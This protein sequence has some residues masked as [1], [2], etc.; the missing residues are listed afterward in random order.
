MTDEATR[1]VCE[2]DGLLQ[3]VVRKLV[4]GEYSNKGV[5]ARDSEYW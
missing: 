1:S 5:S 2:W 3:Q 4:D